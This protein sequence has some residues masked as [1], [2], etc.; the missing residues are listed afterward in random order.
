M[1]YNDSE[2]NNLVIPLRQIEGDSY[3]QSNATSDSLQL[4]DLNFNKLI[5]SFDVPEG[6]KF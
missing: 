4:A 2:L 6:H 1:I 3:R 5:E